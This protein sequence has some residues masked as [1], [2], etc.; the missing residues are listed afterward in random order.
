[1]MRL[2]PPPK[3]SLRLSLSVTTAVQMT[4]GI[5]V[6]SHVAGPRGT[7]QI[8]VWTGPPVRKA[9]LC[10][11]RTP[12]GRDFVHWPSLGRRLCTL[13]APFGRDFEHWNLPTLYKPQSE[14]A[15]QC[16][17]PRPSLSGT[18]QTP[19]KT[20]PPVCKV[21]ADASRCRRRPRA[22]RTSSTDPYIVQKSPKWGHPSRSYDPVTYSSVS[23]Q[24]C[25]VTGESGMTNS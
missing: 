11:L 25:T 8:P 23:T 1:M 14:S 24:A 20:A 15:L 5:P 2:H 3:V 7:V 17:K 18:V 19:C 22:S 4:A 12:F 13:R 16:A 10:T 21:P 6:R 9:R